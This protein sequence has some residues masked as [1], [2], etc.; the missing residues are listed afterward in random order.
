MAQNFHTGYGR[1]LADSLATH[2]PYT[3][4]IFFVLGSSHANW[5]E[6]TELFPPGEGVTRVFTDLQAA[7]D[8]TTASGD[9]V[10]FI[11]PGYTENIT[12]AGDIDINNAH[13]TIIGLGEGDQ[14]PTFTFTTATT[15]DL[16]VDAAGVT[17]ENIRFD[18]TGID[19]LVAPLDINAA[20]C[21][22][23]DCEIILADGSGQA[24][25][26]IL[27]DNSADYL[28][29][30]NCYLHGDSVAGTVSAIR[31]VGSD[32]VEID[33]SIIRGNFKSTA[34]GIEVTTTA[35]GVTIKNSVVEN[36]TGSAASAINILG[37]TSL[38]IAGCSL[39]IGTGT[40]PISINEG[41]NS[42]G[43]GK[44]GYVLTSRNYY[45]NA[46]T[47]AAGTLL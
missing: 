16:N 12:S 46:T 24:I 11:A 5:P 42:N 30:V 23:K 6:I 19:A 26:G 1:M 7:L 22:F 27:T 34:G 15:A 33:D 47:I 8:Q 43:G 3:G 25:V 21:K 14:R 37:G 32:H 36:N 31:I 35:A 28:K 2:R 9:D 18:C 45:R 4:K 29:L 41:A 20:S 38:V 40:V 10:I 44:A 39:R 17:F 13:V